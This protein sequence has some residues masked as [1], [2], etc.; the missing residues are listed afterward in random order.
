[1][2]NRQREPGGKEVPFENLVAELHATNSIPVARHH[3]LA[4]QV[5]AT[6]IVVVVVA[7]ISERISIA[8][9][10]TVAAVSN[11]ALT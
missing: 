6:F 10:A 1:M 7:A 11:S 9:A 5:T 4:N 2:T 8:I 3:A